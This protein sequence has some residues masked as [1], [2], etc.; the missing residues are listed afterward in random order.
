MA[1][2]S[3]GEGYRAPPCCALP[4]ACSSSPLSGRRLRL[5]P[6][7]GRARRSAPGAARAH[8]ERPHDGPALGPLASRSWSAS[9]CASASDEDPAATLALLHEASPPRAT[10]A[11]S[12][13]SPSS[14]S[15]TR[16]RPA[17]AATT[18]C[19]RSTPTRCFSRP[20]T[21]SARRLRPARAARLRSLQPRAHRG[22]GP[23]PVGRGRAE[24]R[25]LR[26][27]LRP[28]RDRARTGGEDS[29]PATVS[30]TSCRRPTTRC[31][32][33][34]I[35]TGGPGSARRSRRR[36][37]GGRTDDAMPRERFMPGIRVPVDRRSSASRLRA[38]ALTHGAASSAPRALHARTRRCTV[39][40]DGH[41][42]A[43][44][45]RGELVPRGDPARTRPF[46]EFEL[47]GFFSGTFRPSARRWR[48]RSWA[49]RPS[50]RSA[51]T[52]ACCS[53]SRTGPGAS[54]WCW[55]TAPPRAPARWA[56]LVNEL[57]N[58]RDDRDALPGLALP[59]QHGQPDRLLGRP[60]ASR[61]RGRRGGARSRTAPTRRSDRWSWSATARAGCSPSSTA[62]DSGR[63][64]LGQRVRACRSTS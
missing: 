13:P 59:L 63:P 19:P 26:A 35:A 45:D 54:R 32:A 39:T 20:R 23:R 52:R 6:R 27:A 36:S 11:G 16:S 17:I 18:S 61:P 4:P 49:S 53:C 38:S 14:A 22:A 55:C 28:A 3:P 48:P 30:L 5:G 10:I 50:S 43:P 64:L 57:E 56:E 31:G 42:R 9:P 60:A 58:D 34:A 47:G 8:R 25:P 51:R 21:K 44:R 37:A 33:S 7:G 40:I 15:I 24:R 46:W 12:R 2:A 41:E 29:G 1:G 62:V